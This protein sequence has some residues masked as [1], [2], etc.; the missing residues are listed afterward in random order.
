[1]VEY[2]CFVCAYVAAV[3]YTFQYCKGNELL[4]CDDSRMTGDY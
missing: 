2:L 4:P 1:M 3:C